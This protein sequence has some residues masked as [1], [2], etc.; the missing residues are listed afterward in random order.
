[1]RFQPYAEFPAHCCLLSQGAVPDPDLRH[2][3][4]VALASAVRREL[5]QRDGGRSRLRARPRRY[6][7]GPAARIQTQHGKCGEQIESAWMC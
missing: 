4:C 7:P 6:G 1:M 3:P 2:R 5:P